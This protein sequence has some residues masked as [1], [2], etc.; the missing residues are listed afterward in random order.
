MAVWICGGI[1]YNGISTNFIRKD[2]QTMD[3]LIT[4]T[5]DTPE[6]IQET[7]RQHIENQ[8]EGNDC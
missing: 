6:Y 3:P 2:T 4:T 1:W 5:I 7:L 8:G